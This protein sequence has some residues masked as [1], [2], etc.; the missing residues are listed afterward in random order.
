MNGE[1][2]RSPATRCPRSGANCIA[3]CGTIRERYGFPARCK[4]CRGGCDRRTLD[5]AALAEH[6]RA[7]ENAVREA[8]AVDQTRFP[9]SLEQPVGPSG[10]PLGQFLG[11]PDEEIEALETRETAYALLETLPESERTVI[12]L[13][14]MHGLPQRQVAKRVGVSQMQVSRLRTSGLQRL[15]QHISAAT[16]S[17]LKHHVSRLCWRGT[18]RFPSRAETP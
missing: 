12:R 15:R 17:R 5:T 3:T 10:T 7:D 9:V 6:V 14:V 8:L 2:C 1:A 11:E 18:S 16:N 13:N 4:N